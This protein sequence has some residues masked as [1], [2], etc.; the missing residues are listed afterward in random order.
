MN[1]VAQDYEEMSDIQLAQ[2]AALRDEIA[3][4]LVTKRN[5]QR[6]FRAAWS[7]L[8]NHADAED[9]VQESYLRAFRSLQRFEGKSSLSTWLTRIVLNT[10]ID[11]KR[12]NDRK[13]KAL[14][15]QDI[16]II[17]AYRSNYS[18]NSEASDLPSSQL[19]RAELSKFLKSAVRRL[20]DPYRTVFVFRDIEGMSITETAEVM[21]IPP[22]TVKTRLFRARRL[23]RKDIEAEFG[24][25]FD[26]TI[27]FA[28]VDCEAMTTRIVGEICP[29]KTGEEE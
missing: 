25:V 18:S 6:M 2:R 13:M 19:A 29:H 16:A 9:V 12:S 27:T 5:N 10:A 1:S 24:D 26:D 8:R 14:E 17:D 28:G 22:A 11:R 15:S 7:V 23:L 4:T 21:E 3:V 20:P